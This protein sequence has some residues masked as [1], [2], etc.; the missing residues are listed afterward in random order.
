MVTHL[1]CPSSWKARG[2]DVIPEPVRN[3]EAASQRWS[4]GGRKNLS[5]DG[6]WLR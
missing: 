4:Y 5:L 3:R 1:T 6:G 2:I